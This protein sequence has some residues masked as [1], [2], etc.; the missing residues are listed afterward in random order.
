MPDL[1]LQEPTSQ[2]GPTGLADQTLLT[3]EEVAAIL[4]V[5]GSWVYGHL[6]LLPVV[7]LGRYVRFPRHAI[8]RIATGADGSDG[9]RTCL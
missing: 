1:R 7:R 6:D 8:D 2:Q 9:A 5:P 3:A 4:R